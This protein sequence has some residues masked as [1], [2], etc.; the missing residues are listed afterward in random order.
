MCRLKQ[1][2]D[3]L[4]F[5]VTIEERVQKAIER[6]VNNDYD[7]VD[8]KTIKKE[9][10]TIKVCVSVL[11]FFLAITIAVLS[12]IN[13]YLSKINYGDIAVVAEADAEA[14]LQLD[15]E[16]EIDFDI[17]D[18]NEI[19]NS[20]ETTTTQTTKSTSNASKKATPS[21]NNNSNNRKPTTTR[22]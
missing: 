20:D 4:K 15:A 1:K 14:E 7:N 22:K 21:K 9:N 6:M 8:E 10:N 11:S 16:E 19:G 2:W 18:Y 17:V 5:V 13:H 12:V 3:I